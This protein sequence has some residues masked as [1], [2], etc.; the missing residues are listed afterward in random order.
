MATIT[1]NSLG[2]NI[3]DLPDLIYGTV[4][5][6]TINGKGGRDIIYAKAGDDVIVGGLDMDTIDGGWGND[7]LYFG[8]QHEADKILNYGRA[9]P[10]T[11]NNDV[12]ALGSSI[13]AYFIFAEA[14]GIRIATVDWQD[15]FGD[16]VQGSITLVGV[17]AAQWVGWGG[18]YSSTTY[19]MRDMQ[20]TN[21]T[22]LI[23]FRSSDFLIA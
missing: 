1:K 21:G 8:A 23:D 20:G 12:L 11:G 19:F 6:D 9:A 18:S 4:G 3:S 15:P 17:T 10:T 13:D 22:P 7:R 16:L 14:A 2:L 5:A